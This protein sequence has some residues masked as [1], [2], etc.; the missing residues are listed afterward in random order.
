MGDLS[1]PDGIAIIAFEPLFHSPLGDHMSEFFRIQI[2][3][4]GILFS[5]KA[6]LRV[7]KKYYR[8][9]DAAERYKEI[10]GELNQIRYSEFLRYVEETGWKFRF[11]DLYSSLKRTPPIRKISNVV[12]RIP[13]IR[14]YFVNSINCI[15][16]RPRQFR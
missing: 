2:P 1:A 9:T 5:E 11:L 10:V 3:W 7:R 12:T 15:L 6:V 16:N 13:V 14:D 4:R 8:P